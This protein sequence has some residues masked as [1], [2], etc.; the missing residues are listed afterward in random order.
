MPWFDSRTFRS[1]LTILV[2]LLTLGFLYLARNTLIAFLFAIFFAYI[3]EPLVDRIQRRIHG[4]R[5]RA[6]ALLYGCL[7]ISIGLLIAIFGPRILQQGEN[8]SRQLPALAA[9]VNSGQIARQVGQERGWS[10][11][12]QITVQRFL[13]AHDSDIKNME[14]W[15]THNAGQLARRS[16][17]L[18]L[19]P[20]LSVFFL[21]DGHEFGSLATEMFQQRRQQEL[22]RGVLS[23]LHN[24]LAQFIRAQLILTG[25]ALVVYNLGFALLRLPYPYALGTMAGLLEFIPMLG[26]LT[27]AALVLTITVLAGYK[28]ILWI[29]IFLGLWR[30]LQDYYNSPKIMGNGVELH[31]LAVIFGALVG[32]EIAGVIGVY[33]SVPVMASL[34]VLL[35][36]WHSYQTVRLLEMPPTAEP[37]T[38]ANAGMGTPSNY[39]GQ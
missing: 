16:W 2:V 13:R 21:K 19:I 20:I 18:V 9:K 5:G 36:R 26:P 39:V 31:P 4:S 8:L 32:G 10:Y 12:T 27:A 11:R 33:L 7:L 34:R 29:L 3:L 15:L 37:S 22:L 1:L 35:R 17:W 6:I 30:L 14:H 23:D 25:F 38:T 28:H 24:V